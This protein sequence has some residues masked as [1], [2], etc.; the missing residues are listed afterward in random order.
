MNN[1]GAI[2][3]AKNV[4]RVLNAEI[5]L[6]QTVQQPNFLTVPPNSNFCNKVMFMAGP[7]AVP[8]EMEDYMSNP[9]PTSAIKE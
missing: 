1:N 3:M 9:P 2:V 7:A 8:A 5:D 6:R 4:W